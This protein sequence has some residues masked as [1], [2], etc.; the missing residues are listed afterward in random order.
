MKTFLEAVD[1]VVFG[2]KIPVKAKKYKELKE[3]LKN[4]PQYEKLRNMWKAIPM[5][6]P[7]KDV[8][9]LLGRDS[10]LLGVMVGAAMLQGESAGKPELSPDIAELEKWFAASVEEAPKPTEEV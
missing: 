7:G 9:Y 1:E 3:E 10:F 4:H 6:A 5:I 8:P 2:G